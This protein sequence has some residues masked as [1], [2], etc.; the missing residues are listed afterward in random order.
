MATGYCEGDGLTKK[1]ASKPRPMSDGSSPCSHSI[2]F[3][4]RNETVVSNSI[5]RSDDDDEEEQQGLS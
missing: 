1:M 4:G 3:N 2:Q 5:T